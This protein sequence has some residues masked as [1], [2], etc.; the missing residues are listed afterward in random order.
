MWTGKK[1][2]QFLLREIEV[3]KTDVEGAKIIMK[4]YENSSDKR[5]VVLENDFPRYLYQDALSKLKEPLYAVLPSGHNS[6]WKVEAIRKSPNTME[7]RKRF[8]ESWRASF[9]EDSKL[10]EI[11][12]V[13]DAI[14]CHQ[15]GF[16]AITLSKEGAIKLA[17][18]ALLA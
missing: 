8:P 5:V 12:G 1:I 10:K 2:T 3:T 17:E 6:M 14:F 11:T 16:L 9:S 4:A 13:T 18:K 15:N 7:N